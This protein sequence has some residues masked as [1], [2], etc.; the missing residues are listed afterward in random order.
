MMKTKWKFIIGAIILVLAFLMVI[1]SFSNSN[2]KDLFAGNQYLFDSKMRQKISQD[3]IA[4]FESTMKIE[5][6]QLA[7]HRIYKNPKGNVFVSLA[8]DPSYS[9][10]YAKMCS[11]PQYE[12]LDDQTIQERNNQY[13]CFFIK[14]NGLYLTRLV[15][16]E[17]E[18]INL[19]VIDTPTKEFTDAENAFENI[20][21]LLPENN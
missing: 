6:F 2:S 16:Y 20:R 19:I 21:Q 13:Y 5:G 17:P 8:M 4:E 3:F 15:Y 9:K 18:L 7:L 10:F 11:D 12:I 1:N 14:R